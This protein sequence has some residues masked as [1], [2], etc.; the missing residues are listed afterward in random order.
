MVIVGPYSS[1][2]SKA[3]STLRKL[4]GA[5]RLVVGGGGNLPFICFHIEESLDLCRSHVTRM[6]HH[7]T[8]PMPA[9]KKRTQYG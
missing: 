4:N 1:L 7:P 6:A 9:D 8:T 3:M 2:A 5:E